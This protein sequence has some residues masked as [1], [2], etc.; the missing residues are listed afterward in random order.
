MIT[1]SWVVFFCLF[2]LR[3][4]DWNSS[5]TLHLC[6]IVLKCW[7]Y[8]ISELTIVI[9]LHI[10]MQYYKRELMI[11]LSFSKTRLLC[12]GKNQ[13]FGF[14]HFLH[15]GNKLI[16]Y[17]AVAWCCSGKQPSDVLNR[18]VLS[19]FNFPHLSRDII[20]AFVFQVV[21]NSSQELKEMSSNQWMSMLPMAT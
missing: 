17:S 12:L 7:Q 9:K 19:F 20:P 14:Q 13:R 6:S 10:M 16:I 3:N 21:F 18:L 8:S 15:L 4:S 11:F 2:V 5:F 1:W